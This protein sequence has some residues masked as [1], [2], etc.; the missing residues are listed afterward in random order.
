[1]TILTQYKWVILFYSAIILLIYLNRKRFDM[2]GIMALYRTKVGLKLMDKWAN[3]HREGLKLLGYI[4]IGA[5]YV[6]LIFITV[7]LIKSLITLF[8]V[9]GAPPA[10][11]PVLPGVKIAGTGLTMPL[12]TGWLVLFVVVLVHEFAHGVVAR[13]HNIKVKNSGLFF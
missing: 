10:V 13:V 3:K 7:V 1:M 2:H 5:A 9:P 8:T 11:S 12:I 4:G 6:G